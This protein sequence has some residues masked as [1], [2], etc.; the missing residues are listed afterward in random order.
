MNLSHLKIAKN[1]IKTVSKLKYNKGK[2]TSYVSPEG[3]YRFVSIQT[4]GEDISK[5]KFLDKINEFIQDVHYNRNKYIDIGELFKIMD[6]LKKRNRIFTINLYDRDN[7]KHTT[8]SLS[9]HYDNKLSNKFVKSVVSLLLKY[10]KKNKEKN[11]INIIEVKRVGNNQNSEKVVFKDEIGKIV[12]LDRKDNGSDLIK[13]KIAIGDSL[14]VAVTTSN[15]TFDF[16]IATVNGVLIDDFITSI[17]NLK[18]DFIDKVY[19][20]NEDF[21]SEV[22]LLLNITNQEDESKNCE[23]ALP[24]LINVYDKLDF[25]KDNYK[26]SGL[27]GLQTLYNIKF[28]NENNNGIDANIGNTLAKKYSKQPVKPVVEKSK[29][30]PKTMVKVTDTSKIDKSEQEILASNSELEQLH[31]ASLTLRSMHMVKEAQAV[32]EKMNVIRNEITLKKVI[33]YMSAGEIYTAILKD[34]T[35]TL[36]TM[37]DKNIIMQVLPDSNIRVKSI[38]PC[39]IKTMYSLTQIYNVSS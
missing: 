38:N 37:N 22:R 14:T 20:K 15:D 13:D 25:K 3:N 34:D 1:A 32:E 6:N 19:D 12:Y 9:Y 18:E 2:I 5:N 8:Y 27:I 16:A 26:H 7:S 30:L 33:Y 23:I 17:P 11:M 10:I 4:Y 39:D 36:V 35:V 28:N 24:N 21:G 29:I 31:K